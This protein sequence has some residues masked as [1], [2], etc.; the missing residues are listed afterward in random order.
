MATMVKFEKTLSGLRGATEGE[1]AQ[2]ESWRRLCGLWVKLRSVPVP[3]GLVVLD[4]VCK[5]RG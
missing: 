1:A 3:P 5:G 4:A 2:G